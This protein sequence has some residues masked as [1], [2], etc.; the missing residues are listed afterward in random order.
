M[1]LIFLFVEMWGMLESR[2][3]GQGVAEKKTAQD[4][5]ADC[6]FL[7]LEEPMADW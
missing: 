6:L 1:P 5:T 3:G 2:G 4:L 7:L